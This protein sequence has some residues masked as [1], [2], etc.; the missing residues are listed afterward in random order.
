MYLEEIDIEQ[1]D[2]S[3]GY[4]TSDQAELL[5]DLPEAPE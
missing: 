1:P 3:L 5:D 4:A 2:V